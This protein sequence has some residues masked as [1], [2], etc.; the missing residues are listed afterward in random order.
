MIAVLCWALGI[1]VLAG[2]LVLV[3]AFLRGVKQHERDTFNN[4]MDR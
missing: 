1:G 4:W 2:L 3:A